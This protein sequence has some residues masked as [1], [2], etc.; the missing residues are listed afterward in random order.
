MI[1]AIGRALISM[2]IRLKPQNSRDF[3]HK[4]GR[5]DYALTRRT[6]HPGIPSKLLRKAGF[7]GWIAAPFPSS[8]ERVSDIHAS[9][10]EKSRRKTHPQNCRSL[11]TSKNPVWPL[12]LM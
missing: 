9:S 5:A 4:M 6:Y 3:E 10:K 1:S 11:D 2:Q 7:G 12:S 8:S